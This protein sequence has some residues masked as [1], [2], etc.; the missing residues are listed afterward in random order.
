MRIMATDVGVLRN[1]SSRVGRGDRTRL[2]G[3]QGQRQ[4]RLREVMV[5]R[6]TV[7]GVTRTIDF[8][9]WT[10]V[11]LAVGMNVSQMVAFEACLAVMG[12]VVREGGANRYAVNSPC[13]IDFMAEFSLL[14]S[15][16]DFWGEWGRRSGWGRLWIGRHGQFFNVTFQ[17]IS[18]FGHL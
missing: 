13:G 16:L 1:H 14:E 8:A 4:G 7:L 15:K 5:E 11:P 9:D 6:A 2:G 10:N 17:V 3:R 12:V 18:I